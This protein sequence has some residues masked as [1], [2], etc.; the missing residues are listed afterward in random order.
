MEQLEYLYEEATANLNLWIH[1]GDEKALE[2][3]EQLVK[4]IEK[5]QNYA[6]TQSLNSEQ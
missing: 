5:L 6:K 2:R 3:Y 4:F 1:Q